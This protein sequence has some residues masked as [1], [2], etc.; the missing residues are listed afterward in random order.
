M[1][2]RDVFKMEFRRSLKSLVIW[3][4]AVGSYILLVVV[5]YPLVKDMYSSMPEE[6]ISYMDMVGGI[7]KNIIEYYA[8]EGALMMQL[9]GAI[10]AA[11]LGFSLL[12]HDEREMTTDVIYTLPVSRK[13]FYYTKLLV[14]FLEILLFSAGVT[15][16]TFVGIISIEKNAAFTSF[17]S[18]NLLNTLMLL[19]MGTLGFALA[20]VTKR[21][22]KTA[23]SVLIPLP[24]YVI[25]FISQLTDNRIVK[26]LKYI[27]AFTFSDPVTIIKT[28]DKI[29]FFTLLA[30]LVLAFFALLFGCFKFRKKEFFQ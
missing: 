19:I 8:I 12:N 28:G 20:A 16:F 4:V 24:L 13:T 1:I 21:T 10:F 25:Y 6:L 2:N 18:F 30:Y 7:P 5:L 3:S 17:F 29:A 11:L 9:A 23:L 14:V 22:T 27:S 15:L 26:N